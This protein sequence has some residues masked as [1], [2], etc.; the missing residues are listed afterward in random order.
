M[1]ALSYSS[2]IVLMSATAA[3]IHKQEGRGE[4]RAWRR[5]ERELGKGQG[6][7]LVPGPT[8]YCPPCLLPSPPRPRDRRGR[9]Y[10]AGPCGKDWGINLSL[11]TSVIYIYC[12]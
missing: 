7:S 2:Y 11:C 5:K 4:K 3:R 10:E 8:L 1:H 6:S 12:T 9:I